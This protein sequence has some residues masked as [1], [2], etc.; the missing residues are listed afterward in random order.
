MYVE[1]GYP[2][3]E[4]MPVY[5]GLPEVKISPREQ[6][7]KGDGWNGSV[8]SI[9]LHAGTHAD[10]PWHYIDD[11]FGI[12]QVPTDNFVYSHPLLVS[13]PCS[14]NYLVT[15]DDLQTAGNGLY[16]ADALFLNTGFWQYR[17]TDFEHYRNNFPTLSPEAAEFIRTHLPKVKAVAIDTLS[18]ENLSYGAV[19]G[20][21][22][23]R[24]LLNP[25]C[26][27]KKTIVIIEDYNPA[28]IVGKDMKSAIAVPLR[29]KDRDATPI[30]IFAEI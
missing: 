29:I 13:I 19:N 26:S 18:I 4:G 25:D 20:Y 15:I 24:T 14:E 27:S 21:K 12:D 9:Y 11:S 16:E 6:I 10:A 30:N 22:T 28:P 17:G 5:P 7:R 23:H 3:Y 2:I 1:L 8:L